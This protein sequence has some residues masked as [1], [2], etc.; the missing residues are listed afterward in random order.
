MLNYIIAINKNVKAIV[1]DYETDNKK[2]CPD[3]GYEEEFEDWTSDKIEYLD[4]DH[5]SFDSKK[6]FKEI[7]LY[8]VYGYDSTIGTPDGYFYE[9][10]VQKIEKIQSFNY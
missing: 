1:I 8:K 7:G 3:I 5:I 2:C 4:L 6:V 9:Y 10:C